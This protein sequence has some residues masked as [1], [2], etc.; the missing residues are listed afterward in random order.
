MKRIFIIIALLFYIYC[1]IESCV[2]EENLSNCQTHSIEFSDMSCHFFE[3]SNEKYCSIYHDNTN[4]QKLIKKYEIGLLKESTSFWENDYDENGKKTFDIDKDIEELNITIPDK[5]NYNKGDTIKMKE[6]PAKD[7]LTIDDIKIIKNGNTCY[8]HIGQNYKNLR[9]IK[10][11]NKSIF[12]IM[13]IDSKKI[14]I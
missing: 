1:T 11:F 14:K 8:N 6:L 3:E 4:V 9:F 5:D 13:W 10:S 2:D 7:Y 12:T